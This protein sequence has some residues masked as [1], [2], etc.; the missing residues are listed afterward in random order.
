MTDDGVKVEQMGTGAAEKRS[1]GKRSLET[2]GLGYGKKKKQHIDAFYSAMW[3][4]LEGAGW[5]QVKGEGKNEGVTYFLPPGVTMVKKG[6]SQEEDSSQSPSKDNPTPKVEGSW[7]CESCSR[8]NM[9]AS[10]RCG[11]CMAWRGGRRRRYLKKVRDVIERI[12]QKKND[13][14]ARAADAFVELVPN[15][16]SMFSEQKDK[17]G[18][19]SPDKKCGSSNGKK[20][21]SPSKEKSL[22]ISSA[23]KDERTHFEKTSSRVGPEFQ[24]DLLPAAGSYTSKESASCDGNALFEQVW[25]PKEAEKSGKLDFVDTR[26][27]FNRRE[28][29]YNMLHARGYCLPGFY[30]EICKSNPSDGSDWTKNDKDNFQSAVFEHHEN[31]RE[32]SKMIGKPID[33]CITVRLILM[34]RSFV[35]L[36]PFSFSAQL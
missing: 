22:D 29:A 35:E 28:N 7:I 1:G 15:A 10:S 27:K 14:D 31:M 17:K 11:Q 20:S 5:S 6:E 3:P 19:P 32:V 36:N 33:Q 18:G 26:V 12:L 30:Q 9:K 21:K 25:D 2:S 8:N 4:V 24:V 34:L 23:W 13:V 16:Y